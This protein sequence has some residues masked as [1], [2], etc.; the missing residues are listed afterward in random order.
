MH[1]S[2]STQGFYPDLELYAVLPD[3][4]VE[5]GEKRHAE[6]LAAINLDRKRFVLVEGELVAEDQ[7]SGVTWS[8][9]R[10]ERNKL[11]ALCDYTQTL[12]FPEDKRPAWAEYRAALRAIPETF[13]TPEEVV[14]PEP[15]R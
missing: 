9:I 12:D 11:L 15:P 4:L 10:I 2:P 1:F 3:D 8:M 7:P 13:A 14:W 6:M 5:I